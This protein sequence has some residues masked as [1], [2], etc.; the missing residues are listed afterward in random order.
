ME[1]SRSPSS[2][3]GCKIA[4]S[5]SL[6]VPTAIISVLVKKDGNGS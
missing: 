6:G 4:S 5:P 1:A 3:S 2:T